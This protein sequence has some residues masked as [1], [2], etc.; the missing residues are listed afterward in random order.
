MVLY[1]Y[2]LCYCITLL[3]SKHTEYDCHLKSASSS[4][5]LTKLYYLISLFL[6]KVIHFVVCC[7][8]L[9]CQ[10]KIILKYLTI[11]KQE[12]NESWKREFP[13]EQS[14]GLASRNRNEC[15]FNCALFFVQTFHMHKKLRLLY[16]KNCF[17]VC[18]GE[19]QISQ[20][21]ICISNT[22]ITLTILY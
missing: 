12:Q 9:S 22:N 19:I 3:S 20:L 6:K 18:H 11:E 17:T 16:L 8:E 4:L 21:Q 15:T 10:L 2:A 1:I 13:Q 7:H 14:E 5:P